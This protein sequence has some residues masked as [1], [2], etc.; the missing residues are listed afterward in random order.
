MAKMDFSESTKVN[1]QDELGQ[2]G[3]SLNQLSINL[4]HHITALKETNEQLQNDIERERQIEL[5][6]RELI[7]IN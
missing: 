5:A 4:Q 1:G 7:P 2:L 3:T 6:R